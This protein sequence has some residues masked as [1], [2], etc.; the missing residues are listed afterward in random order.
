MKLKKY[1]LIVL[2][3]LLTLTTLCGCNLFLEEEEVLDP[4]ALESDSTDYLTHKVEKGDLVDQTIYNGYVVAAAEYEYSFGDVSG[5]LEDIY[6][7]AGQAVKKGQKI[8]KLDTAEP[9]NELRLQELYVEKAQIAYDKAVAENANSADI[10]TAKLNLEIE[11]TKLQKYKNVIGGSVLYA[12]ADGLVSYVDTVASGDYIESHKTI[13]KIIDSSKIMVKY[14]ASSV[15]EFSLGQEVTLRYDNVLYKGVISDIPTQIN[16]QGAVNSVYATFVDKTPSIDA[17]GKIGDIILVHDSRTDVVKIAKQFV[18][19]YDG[20]K[21][22]YILKNGVRTQQFIEV[23][24]E[25]STECEIVSG[26]NAGD[27]LIIS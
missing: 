21:Y 12:T 4:P 19:T 17:I 6:V 18:K 5:K 15:S 26:L 22:V 2:S 7:T 24:L 27:L 13:I 10:K 25:G 3:L 14:E 23:G 20:K 1:F 11:K 9:E 16:T 8:A